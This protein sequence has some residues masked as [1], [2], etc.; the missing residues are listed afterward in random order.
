[1][2]IAWALAPKPLVGLLCVLFHINVSAG[3]KP[4]MVSELSAKKPSIFKIPSSTRFFLLSIT[5]IQFIN[6]INFSVHC[7][8]NYEKKSCSEIIDAITWKLL[9][10]LF[11]TWTTLPLFFLHKLILLIT[12]IGSGIS[13]HFKVHLIT[14]LFPLQ[15]S[16]ATNILNRFH[17]YIL[18]L[19]IF[20]INFSLK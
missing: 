19:F 12:K 3:W 6:W 17:V 10:F 18:I 1:M 4:K 13:L 2:G 5:K 7:W 8:N 11:F 15:N 9:I 16:S 14:W 20:Y